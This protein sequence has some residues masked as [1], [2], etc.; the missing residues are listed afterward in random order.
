MFLKDGTYYF[1]RLVPLDVRHFYLRSRMVICL[2]AQNSSLASRSCKSISSKLDDYWMKLRLT[3]IAIPASHLLIN[4][5]GPESV[6][7]K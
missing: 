6:L 3:E 5:N 7:S 1:S 2:K 4:G